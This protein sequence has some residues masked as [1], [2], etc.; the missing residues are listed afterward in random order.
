MTMETLTKKDIQRIRQKAQQLGG[1]GEY[2]A[3]RKAGFRSGAEYATKFEREKQSIIT[4]KDLYEK[5]LLDL[6]VLQSNCIHPKQSDWIEEQWAP[7]HGT[8]FQ[9]RICEGCNMI[10]DRR[11]MVFNPPLEG[12]ILSN[13]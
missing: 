4:A 1:L 6:K 8:G 11:P 12:F 3:A 9:V 7:A 10:I 5:Y 13:E 2:A